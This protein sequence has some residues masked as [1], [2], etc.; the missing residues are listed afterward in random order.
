M[1]PE[2]VPQM[3]ALRAEQ[4]PEREAVIVEGVASMTFGEWD[5]RSD[6]VAHGLLDRGVRRGDRIG[7]L[8]GS[9]D[10]VDFA[11]AYCAVQ[12]TGAVAVPLSDRLA[13]AEVRH[14]LE[15]CSASALLC[16]RDLTPPEGDRW[17]AAV[18][19][20]EGG[21]AGPPGV[22]VEPADL[23]Q[24]LYTSGTTG[25]PKGVGASH[26][27]LA[28][29][30]ETRPN[31]RRFGHSRHLLHAFPIGTNAGQTMLMNALDARP[32][33]LTLGRFT[34]G[35]LARLIESRRVGTVFVV[36]A[37]AIEFLN[38]GLHERHDM[39]SVLLLGSA[40]S[41]LPPAVAAR[42]ADAFPNATVTNYYTSTEAAPAQTIMIFDPS[43]PGALG[44]P[45]FG[46]AL[47]ITDAHGDPLPPGEAGEVWMRSPT[48]TRFYYR[49]EQAGAEAFRGGWVR[50]GDIG[51]LDAEGYLHLVD[52]ES[53]VVKSGAFKVSTLQ[54]E[55]A[56]H[57]HEAVAEAAVL[58]VPHP[59]LGSVLAAAVVLRS[60]GTSGG[61]LRAFLMD[62]LAGH[63]LP[64]RVLVVDTLPRNQSGK[65]VKREL[66]GL[67]EVAATGQT[68]GT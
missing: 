10:W 2:T 8:F 65:V 4:D 35:R 63:E 64:E 14:M 58:G 26:A 51:R 52:R 45:A 6:D 50:M 30:C 53:D 59:V 22:R 44:R 56:L 3:L 20:L 41:A 68:E 40:A 61:D 21:T 46:G 60:A 47:R 57:E 33:M 36:P 34:P 62:R 17:S 7:L 29:G 18:A 27:N 11:V 31:R 23:A 66:R 15:H 42:L 55:A 49:D 12:K 13:P 67:F 28:F 16:G 48:A 39:S 43:R 19:E 38:A 25:L 9:R 24:I 5:R 37:M 1:S 32:A 54:V